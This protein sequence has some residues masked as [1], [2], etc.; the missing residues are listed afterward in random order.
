MVVMIRREDVV[1]EL[2]LSFAEEDVG[3]IVWKIVQID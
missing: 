2:V 3:I 1:E